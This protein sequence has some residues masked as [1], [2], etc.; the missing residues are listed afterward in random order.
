MTLLLFCLMRKY[1]Q[2]P[3]IIFIYATSQP[4]IHLN[5]LSTC[6]E[7]LKYNFVYL[8]IPPIM[9]KLKYIMP[10][11]YLGMNKYQ[12]RPKVGII[13]KGR[14]KVFISGTLDKI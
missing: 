9:R 5:S 14:G 6:C 7:I 1:N 12:L 10:S 13:G 8:M 3:D 11:D 2:L 4:S